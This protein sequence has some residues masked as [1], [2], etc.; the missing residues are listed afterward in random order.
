L[1]RREDA[2]DIYN[3]GEEKE[4]LRNVFVLFEFGMNIT[5]SHYLL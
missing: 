3:R 2:D 4:I 5:M 1:R